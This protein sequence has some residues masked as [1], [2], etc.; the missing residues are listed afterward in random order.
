MSS[1]CSSAVPTS[2]VNRLVERPGRAALGAGAVVGQ[3]HHHGVVGDALLV[4]EV[5]DPPEV[6]VGVGDEA[7]EDL[8]VAGEEPTLVLRQALPLRHPR[9]PLGQHGLGRHHALGDL[10]V[11]G[12]PAPGLPAVVE[13]PAVRRHPL[14]GD[15]VGSVRGAGGQVAE[16]RLAGGGLLLVPDHRDRLVDQVLGEVV[17]LLGGA[18]RLHLGVVADQ[19]GRP[20]VGLGAEEAVVALEPEAERPPVERPGRGVLPL[21]GQVPLPHGH[22]VV[23]VV[24]Q[25]PR[26][27]GGAARDPAVVAREPQRRLLGHAHPDRMVVAAG[28][29][30]GPGRRAHGGDVEAVVAQSVGGDPVDVRRLEAGAEAAELGEAGAP[31]PGVG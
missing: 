13:L 1:M 10:S 19:L 14:L 4:E 25:H 21:R 30:R 7:R 24:A 8:H 31:G 6:V 29:Q 15:L 22:R 3:D 5:E 27:R 2:S 16:E 20:L 26:Q 28:Q 9:R 11:V 18:G 17:A 23:A 12:T